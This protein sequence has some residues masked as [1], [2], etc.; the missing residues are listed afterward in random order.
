MNGL[1]PQVGGHWQNHASGSAGHVQRNGPTGRHD[2][3]HADP[4]SVTADSAQHV[5][6]RTATR[7]T[8]RIATTTIKAMTTSTAAGTLITV[9]TVISTRRG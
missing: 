1:N 8:S 2:P 3:V 4:A 5:H 7:S 6:G 9:I